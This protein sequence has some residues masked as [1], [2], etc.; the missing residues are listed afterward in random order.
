MTLARW[1]FSVWREPTH[2]TGTPFLVVARTPSSK[3]FDKRKK[4]I[5]LYGYRSAPRPDVETTHG[6]SV[7]GFY[8]IL[9]HFFFLSLSCVLNREPRSF[10]HSATFVFVFFLVYFKAHKVACDS[11]DG[12]NLDLLDVCTN[13]NTMR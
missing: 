7:G 11:L 10:P 4:N 9:F 12:F 13:N 2:E 1:S 3:R 6:R 8:F 5:Y